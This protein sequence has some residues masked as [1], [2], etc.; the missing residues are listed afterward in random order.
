MKRILLISFLTLFL[1][2]ANA[3]ES[4]K[5][6]DCLLAA[7]KV[8][9]G[10]KAPEYYKQINDLKQKSYR[11][12]WYPQIGLNAQATYQSDV[13][14]IDLSGL[15][16]T[17]DVPSPTKDQYKATIDVNQVIWDGGASKKLQELS[18]L[19]MT[20]NAQEN[21]IQLYKYKENICNLYLNIALLQQQERVIELG[22]TTLREQQKKLESGVK[23][24]IILPSQL[25]YIKAELLELEKSHLVIFY[26]QEALI[27]SLNLLTD[28][29]L[30]IN[31]KFDDI[32]YPVKR[33][34]RGRPEIRSFNIQESLI[35]K[36]AELSKTKRIPKVYAFGQIGYG[37][38]GLNFLND[39]FSEFYIVGA[40]LSWNIWDWN[41][42]KNEREALIMQKQLIRIRESSFNQ[43]TAIELENQNTNAEMYE[44]LIANDIEIIAFR[45]KISKTAS[46]QLEEGIITSS[47]YVKVFN[48]EKAARLSLEINKVKE[49][50]TV[51]KREILLGNL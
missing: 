11:A 1:I 38:P 5:L 14:A 15:P 44:D 6:Y 43:I 34:V 41:Q 29:Q 18:T 13:T 16:F 46:K 51:L 39:E 45:E 19:E 32:Y 23:N 49:Q 9:P 7:E 4:V 33:G 2:D 31:D 12:Y 8:F 25:D 27:K 42:N 17:V 47:E 21:S 35:D 3:Q 26:Q 24:G 40:A 48:E 28:L 20:L 22:K 30:S 37:K 36:K 50:Q 10:V